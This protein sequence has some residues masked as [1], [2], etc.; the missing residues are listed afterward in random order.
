MLILGGY[1]TSTASTNA[2]AVYTD[3]TALTTFLGAK[4]VTLTA[5]TGIAMSGATIHPLHSPPS[6]YDWTARH[7][8]M[9]RLAI[10]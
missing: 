2:L 1:V 8:V 10:F 6:F 5:G 7:R 3:A 4:Q 9:Q